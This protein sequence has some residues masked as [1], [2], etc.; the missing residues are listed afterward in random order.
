M[1]LTHL[2]QSLSDV[3]AECLFG[4]ALLNDAMTCFFTSFPLATPATS[5]GLKFSNELVSG[6]GGRAIDALMCMNP[7][8]DGSWSC[9][10]L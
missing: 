8:P 1:V 10:R 2:S 7:Y 5:Q 9:A 3:Q 6:C 4:P